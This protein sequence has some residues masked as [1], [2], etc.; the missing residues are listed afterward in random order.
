MPDNEIG[1]DLLEFM[2]FCTADHFYRCCK[3]HDLCYDAARDVD[4]K[5][6]KVTEYLDPYKWECKNKVPICLGNYF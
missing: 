6:G 4:H 5:C 3:E 2:L 1:T